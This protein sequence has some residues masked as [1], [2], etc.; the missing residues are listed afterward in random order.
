MFRLHGFLGRLEAVCVSIS[1]ISRLSFEISILRSDNSPD[2][3]RS[4][5]ASNQRSEPPL[6][7]HLLKLSGVGFGRSGH[8]HFR[9]PGV[10]SVLWCLLQFARV[11][12]SHLST[13]LLP[14]NSEV[15]S[16]LRVVETR[17][18][19]LSFH[20]QSFTDWLSASLNSVTSLAFS[21]SVSTLNHGHCPCHFREASRKTDRKT[22]DQVLFS[23]PRR[24][25]IQEGWISREVSSDLSEYQFPL[26]TPIGALMSHADEASPFVQ[27]LFVYDTYTDTTGHRARWRA[28]Y[29]D[30][31]KGFVEDYVAGA[32]KSVKCF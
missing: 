16:R 2:S 13:T 10:H 17:L 30:E 23:A 31:M 21:K 29:V 15:C 22:V 5:L 28:F 8:C 24:R 18:R 6:P 1:K 4:P 12:L 27:V 25:G 14:F 32:F 20:L 9:D 26:I 19:I 3:Q 11:F 7:I